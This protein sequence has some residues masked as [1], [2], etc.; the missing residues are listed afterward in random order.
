MLRFCALAGSS[1]DSPAPIARWREKA[2]LILCSPF[3]TLKSLAHACWY[4]L[5][6]TPAFG[7]KIFSAFVPVTP[8][9]VARG[10]QPPA[11]TPHTVRVRSG[12]SCEVSYAPSR[13]THRMRTR[14]ASCACAALDWPGRVSSSSSEPRGQVL[15]LAPR[16]AGHVRNSNQS[17]DALHRQ[18]PQLGH[19]GHRDAALS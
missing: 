13:A 6:N 5:R 2:G 17:A 11:P 19:R 4:A 15:P 7:S 10:F 3:T 14:P 18:S 12:R 9:R 16:I 1:N 8:N